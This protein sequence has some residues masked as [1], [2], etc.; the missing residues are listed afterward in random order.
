MD[1]AFELLTLMQ[2]GKSPIV[3]LVLVDSEGS[4][5]WERWR[6]FVVKELLDAQLISPADMDLFLLTDDVEVA[7]D[8]M[9]RFYTTYHSSRVVGSKLVMRL[10]REIGD[11]ELSELNGQFGDIIDSGQIERV[12]ATPAE[13]RDNDHVN[14]SRIA[15]NFDRHGYARLRVLINALNHAPDSP[16]I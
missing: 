8:E 10:K 11:D 9:A 7:A 15:F 3:P 14:L 2:T 16:A 1:E 12:E 6:D 4:T 13:V 5:Y